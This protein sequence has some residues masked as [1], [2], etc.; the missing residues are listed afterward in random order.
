MTMIMKKITMMKRVEVERIWITM[1][2]TAEDPKT[3]MIMM[4][5][6]LEI[7]MKN[8]RQSITLFLTAINIRESYEL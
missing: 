6:N 4:K 8:M 5:N 7:P 3:T 1:M 2:N